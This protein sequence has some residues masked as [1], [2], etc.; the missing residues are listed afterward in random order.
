MGGGVWFALNQVVPDPYRL[1]PASAHNSW[2]IPTILPPTRSQR[3]QCPGYG[4]MGRNGAVNEAWS[5]LPL[6]VRGPAQNQRP[7]V[8]LLPTPPFRIP[9]SSQEGKSLEI[10]G[11]GW[12]WGEEK[13][14]EIET[15]SCARGCSP[16]HQVWVGGLNHS[17]KGRRNAPQ[18]KALLAGPYLRAGPIPCPCQVGSHAEECLGVLGSPS[19]GMFHV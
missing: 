8:Y 6:R 9:V 2:P 18:G 14:C 4:S 15:P 5:H 3:L 19:S 1:L 16:P 13:G 10:W 7:Q 11:E 17:V 12:R